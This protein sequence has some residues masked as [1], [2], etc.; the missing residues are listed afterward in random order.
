MAVSLDDVDFGSVDWSIRQCE[1]TLQFVRETGDYD[2]LKYV[3]MDASLGRCGDEGPR[4]IADVAGFGKPGQDV[5]ARCI[6]E[7][8]AEREDAKA[9]GRYDVVDRRNEI[10]RVF[11]D[12]AEIELD[13]MS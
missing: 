6:E 4:L 8:T 7:I 13:R 2:V 5:I 3:V 11:D 12:A 9:R 1:E 10:L